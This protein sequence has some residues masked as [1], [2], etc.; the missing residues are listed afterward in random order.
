MTSS[1]HSA[2]QP[3]RIF[4]RG[5]RATGVPYDGSCPSPGPDDA[6]QTLQLTVVRHPD[7]VSAMI[8]L[9]GE[10]DLATVPPL[11]E[12]LDRC[13]SEGVLSIDVDT[14][15]VTFCDASGLNV[16]LD[17]ARRARAAAGRLLLHRPSRQLAH[18]L[19]VTGTGAYLLPVP[20]SPTAFAGPA[21][22]AGHAPSNPAA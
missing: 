19:D 7:A 18:L 4:A 12:A 8:R 20:G 10:I 3:I 1:G 22:P 21:D 16:F 15:S 13:L 11:R 6:P 5:G 17:A 9:A 14:R 2:G